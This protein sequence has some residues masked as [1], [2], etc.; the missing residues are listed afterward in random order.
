METRTDI[1]IGETIEQIVFRKF[2]F[3]EYPDKN[4]FTFQSRRGVICKECGKPYGKHFGV[5]CPRIS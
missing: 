3:V 1:Q 2:G 5:S 4:I